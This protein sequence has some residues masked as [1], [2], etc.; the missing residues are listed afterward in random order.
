MAINIIWRE[1]EIE[2]LRRWWGTIPA[3]R[4]AE[5]LGR[6]RNSVI[7]AAHRAGLPNLGNPVGKPGFKPKPE[8][9]EA[10]R[11]RD[12]NGRLKRSQ[13]KSKPAQPNP[14]PEQRHGIRAAQA[15]HERALRSA[16]AS[17]QNWSLRARTEPPHRLGPMPEKLEPDVPWNGNPVTLAMIGA[18][19]CRWIQGA[20]VPGRAHEAMCCGDSVV[21]PGAPYCTEH[22]AR[23]TIR[24]TAPSEAGGMDLGGLMPVRVA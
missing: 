17:A 18:H 7:G 12:E 22:T 1:P 9:R 4:I 23:A 16:T 14:T 10:Y 2:Y 8:P 6:T 13:R 3:S 5:T 21:G 24:R 20:T 15:E 11:R 19:Q